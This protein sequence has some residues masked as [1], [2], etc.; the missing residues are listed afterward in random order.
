M[1]SNFSHNI[2]R[3]LLTI[4]LSFGIFSYYI[5]LILQNE[6]KLELKKRPSHII[7]NYLRFQCECTIIKIKHEYNGKSRDKK[8]NLLSS[9]K[10]QAKKI[11][12]VNN[13]NSIKNNAYFLST[14]YVPN[15]IEGVLIEITSNPFGLAK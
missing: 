12:E 9:F 6:S 8:R 7:S 4:S 2:V 11:D 14:Y 10:I 15:V 5:Y 3:K 13:M 1:H